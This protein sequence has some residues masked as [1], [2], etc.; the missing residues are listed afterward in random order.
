MPLPRTWPR[1]IRSA[2][3]TPKIVLSGTA[4]SATSTVS[5]SACTASGEV[6]ASQAASNPCSNAR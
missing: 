1:T 3:Q 4:I 6:I 5:Q 2:Q